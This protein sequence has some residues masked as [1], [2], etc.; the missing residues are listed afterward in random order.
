MISKGQGMSQIFDFMFESTLVFRASV[1]SGVKIPCR[2]GLGRMGRSYWVALAVGVLSASTWR[3]GGADLVQA[4]E[5]GESV[6]VISE[7]PLKVRDD[8]V[9]TLYPGTILKIT[10]ANGKWFALEGQRGWLDGRFVKTVEDAREFYT[11]RVGTQP[12]DLAAWSILG[13]IYFQLEAYPMSIEAYN[14]ALKLDSKRP[15]LFN[16]RGLTLAAQGRFELAEKDFSTAIRLAPK[17]AQAYANLGFLYF[18][19]D[20]MNDAVA[21]YNQAISLEKENP[22]HYVNRGGC[23]R[24]LGRLEEAMR[25][26]TRATELAGNM[27]QAYVGQ[28]TILMDR[29]ELDEARAAADK[30]MTLDPTNAQAW[31]N[32]GWIEHL[33]GNSESALQDLSKALELDKDSM[34]G[35]LNRS[36]VHLEL[37]QYSEALKDLEIARSMDPEH[38]GVWLNLGEWHWQQRQFAEAQAAYEKSLE[39]GPQLAESLNG[40]AWF[41]ATCPEEGRRKPGRA[42]ELAKLANAASGDRDWSHLDTLAAAQAANGQFEEAVKTIQN[43]LERAPADKKNVLSERLEAYRAGT[44]YRY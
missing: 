11:K 29:L 17:Y 23:F 12:Q 22:A 25:D 41:L 16:N 35:R 30:A 15:Q 14:Q 18:S 5:I 9:G 8:V 20:R 44:P 43:A 1:R 13:T 21:Q 40:L 24:E 19:N 39:F 42:L 26:F 27:P 37:K 32:R 2:G 4:Q 3:V 31:I 34:I 10:Q 7:A 36:A 38:P 33:K 28:S 6:V